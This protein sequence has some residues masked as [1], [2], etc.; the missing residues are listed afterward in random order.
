M[1]ASLALSSKLWVFDLDGTLIDS[2]YDLVTAVNATLDNLGLSPLP[3]ATIVSYI[4]DGAEDLIRRSLETAGMPSPEIRGI[5]SETMRW[6]LDYYGEHCLDRTVPYP[7]ALELLDAVAA[8]GCAMAVLTN[9]PEKPALKIL[10]N[11]GILSRFTHVI[12]GDGPLGKKPDPTGLAYIL[13]AV[14][15]LPHESVL[16]GDSLQDLQTARNAGVSFIAFMGGL[17]DAG[18]I[19]AATPDVEVTHLSEITALLEASK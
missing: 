16:V 1:S 15:T 17:G 2:R 14:N 10:E 7:G 9:K 11:M 3:E 6:F 8:R 19:T 13:K 4:G 12:P 5:F 18:A